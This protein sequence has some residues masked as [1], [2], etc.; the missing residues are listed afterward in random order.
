MKQAG[1][2]TAI[3]GGIMSGSAQRQH[4]AVLDGLRGLAAIVVL[5][6]HVSKVG[7]ATTRLFAHG[8]LAVDFFFML[9]G[10]VLAYSYDDRLK[11][12]RLAAGTFVRAR[13]VRLL[14]MVLFGLPLGAAY[15][16]VFRPTRSPCSWPLS[17]RAH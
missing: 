2:N 3:T 8:H 14:P 10:F 12:E 6:Y 16:A 11:S 9:S 15:S 4:F 1:Q 17:P 5:F 7:G 13:A